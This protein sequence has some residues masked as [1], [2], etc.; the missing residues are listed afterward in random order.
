GQVDKEGNRISS[1]TETSG[2]YHTDWLNRMYPRL[3]LARNLQ[4]DDGV[5]FISID[6]GEVHNLRKICDEV[7]GEGNFITQICHKSRASISNDKIISPNHNTI[8]FYTKNHTVIHEKRKF[9]GLDPN[10]EGFELDDNDGRGAY[11]L[12][13]VDGPGGATKG[14]PH[15]E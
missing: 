1:N 7:F 11:R 2:R 13:P 14:N 6:D 4:T 10:L 12:V 5:I 8:M 15:Y 9:I 3:R